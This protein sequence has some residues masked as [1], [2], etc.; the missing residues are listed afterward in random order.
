[1]GLKVSGVKNIFLTK[2]TIFKTII[3]INKYI[4]IY[5]LN[6]QKKEEIK[7]LNELAIY[8][9]EEHEK[10]KLDNDKKK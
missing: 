4:Y 10:K 2:I 8:K 5:F 6:Y 9:K 1:M 7:A 3:W